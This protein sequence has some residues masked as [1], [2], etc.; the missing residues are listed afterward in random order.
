VEVACEESGDYVVRAPRPGHGG[1][2]EVLN[3]QEVIKA[4]IRCEFAPS[5]TSASDTGSDSRPTLSWF[6]D[7]LLRNGVSCETKRARIVGRESIKRRYLVEFECAGQPQGLV[8]MVP[9]SGDTVNSFESMNCQTA[10]GRGIH[11]Q[12][13][14]QNAPN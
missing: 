1:T 13:S 12:L 14:E 4:G 5:P 11:C 6:K 8:A 9:A 2:V 3:C 10:A 7:A